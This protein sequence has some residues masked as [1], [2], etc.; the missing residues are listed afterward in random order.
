[1]NQP[2]MLH[3]RFEELAWSYVLGAL[4]GEDLAAF[5]AHLKEGCGICRRELPELEATAR[6]LL[7]AADEVEPSP[8]LRSRI[9]AAAGAREALKPS[10][11]RGAHPDAVR[12][13]RGMEVLDRDSRRTSSRRE[14]WRSGLALAAVAVL[15][16]LSWQALSLKA[17]LRDALGEVGEAR[18]RIAALE[19][20]IK[21]LR[22]TS[23][24]HNLLVR[25]LNRPESG[26][27][28]LAS[29]APAPNAAGKVLWDKKEGK[30]YLWV[31]NL[32]QEAEG[33]DYQLWAIAGGVPKSA[34]VFSVSTGGSALVPLDTVSPDQPVDAF[35][36]TLEPAG[37]LSAPSGEMV[38]LGQVRS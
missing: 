11:A 13:A 7:L 17:H 19:G 1:M 15:A 33:K 18:Q 2:S 21:D 16:I 4:D 14:A 9:L 22:A 12:A 25:L 20:E 10:P 5:E 38:L 30:G 27:V 24:Q 28:T 34:G 8:A 32:P 23:D 6:A 35:A 26:L 3:S 31:S 36:V 29:L 37:G